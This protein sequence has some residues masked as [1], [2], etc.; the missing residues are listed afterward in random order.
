MSAVAT[1]HVHFLGICGYAVSGAA[2][3]AKQLGYLV[4]GSDE[5][6]YPPTTDTLTAAGIQWVNHHAA[7]NLDMA[8]TPDLVVVGNQVRDGNVEWAEATRRGLPVSSE[9]E[10][11][12]EL[13]RDRV[14]IAV[15]GTH[16]KTTTSS[17]LAWMLEVAGM[18]PG[19]R[20]GTT[21]RDFEATARL[22]EGAPFVFEGDEYTTAPWDPRPKFL[23][24][25]PFAA[26]VTRLELDHPDVYPDFAAYRAP[27]V[28]LA[29][30]MPEDGVLAL[31]A[32]DPECVALQSQASCRTV[33]YGVSANADW[34]VEALGPQSFRVVRRDGVALPPVR[35]SIPGEHNTLN[36]TAALILAGAVGADLER[37]IEACATF[38]GASRRFEILGVA[39][40]VTVVDDYAHHPTEVAATVAA[41]R[42][43]FPEPARIMAV[44]VPHTYSRT[45]A[46]LDDYADA[47]RGADVVLLGPIEPARERHLAHTVSIEDVAARVRGAGEVHIVGGSDEALLQILAEARSGDA[48]LCMSVR[49]FDDLA[50]RTLRALRERSP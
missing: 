45:L 34:R 19:F 10:F 3:V 32:D 6:A 42:Q 38:R 4:T 5:D 33:L 12:A 23:H 31:C 11:Y 18:S 1:R 29:R 14:R 8:G 9:A 36:A 37:C 7:A 49:G 21:S 47:F 20:L 50:K 43:R 41:A 2:L 46:L 30:T 39:G 16:G 25:H 40:G 13:T 15:C 28:E 24:T 27:F 35:L 44:Y 22:G 17:L 26:C 48:V